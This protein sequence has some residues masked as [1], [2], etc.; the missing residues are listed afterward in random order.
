MESTKD[1]YGISQLFKLSASQFPDSYGHYIIYHL[2]Q[3]LLTE[4]SINNYTRVILEVWAPFLYFNMNPLH[5]LTE[6]W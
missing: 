5:T 2:S 1:E 6:L 3:E 4:S